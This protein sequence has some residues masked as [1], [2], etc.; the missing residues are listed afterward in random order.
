M[1]IH[2]R[3]VSCRAAIL[4]S[5]ATWPAFAQEPSAPREASEDPSE[6]TSDANPAPSRSASVE[7][8]DG[9][10][11]KDGAWDQS[12]RLED[13][14]DYVGAYRR[15]VCAYGQDTDSYDVVMR[16]AWLAYR[17]GDYA[18][19]EGLYRSASRLPGANEESARG[20]GVTLIAWGR[21]ELSAGNHRKARRYWR[22]ALREPSSHDEAVALLASYPLRPVIEP[23]V[24]G[25]YRAY[26]L[27]KTRSDGGAVFVQAAW[28]V[29]EIW[30][31]RS[32]YRLVSSTTHAPRG[33]WSSARQSRPSY[34][35]SV[36]EIYL[37]VGANPK[38]YGAD[39]L[40]VAIASSEGATVYGGGGRVRVGHSYGLLGDGAFLQQSGNRNAQGGGSLFYWPTKTVGVQAG[41]L[42]TW[43]WRGR[44]QSIFGGASLQGRYIT[45]HGRV[46]IGSEWWPVDVMSSSVMTI[47]AAFTSG[48]N[49]LMMVRVADAWRVGMHAQAE[50]LGV[51]DAVGYYYHLAAGVQWQP[52]FEGEEP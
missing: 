38:Y 9:L 21:R 49:G 27:G 13:S 30:R 46:H 44:G 15:L 37:G 36:H 22:Q 2:L 40:G 33:P 1:K 20:V 16:L 6:S 48:A 7:G 18:N 8:C 41:L 51:E 26:S 3:C 31:L 5:F 52:T 28:N 42:A 17:Q 25:A 34:V 10:M 23:E 50:R 47:P 4:L 43:D 14:G 45:L 12:V 24:W 11:S 19:A 39:V 32:A 35:S 29:S